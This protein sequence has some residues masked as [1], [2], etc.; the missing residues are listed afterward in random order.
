MTIWSRSRSRTEQGMA[1]L[2]HPTDDPILRPQA[3]RWRAVE[4][5]AKKVSPDPKELSVASDNPGKLKSRAVLI[6]ANHSKDWDA[7]PRV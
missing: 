7:K 6:K 3:V 4:P 5:I 2:T 1:S